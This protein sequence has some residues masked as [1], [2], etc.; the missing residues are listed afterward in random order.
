VPGLG[1]SSKQ[2]IISSVDWTLTLMLISSILSVVHY[3]GE[4]AVVRLRCDTRRYL[5]WRDLYL[6]SMAVR[7]H[8]RDLDAADAALWMRARLPVWYARWRLRV[9]QGVDL[10]KSGVH[11]GVDLAKSGVSQGV[12]LLAKST[13]AGQQPESAA[14]GM[15]RRL[16]P[17]ASRRRTPK[18]TSSRDRTDEESVGSLPSPIMR[19]A[20]ASMSAVL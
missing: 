18:P 15:A 8:R 14:A 9:H 7:A 2:S 4:M 20:G 5:N 6:G 12:D 11:Q 3:P 19:E 13:L 10:A 1:A 17:W 16:F